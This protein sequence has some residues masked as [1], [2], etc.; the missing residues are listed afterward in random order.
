MI[1]G[2]YDTCPCYP[3]NLCVVH[4]LSQVGEQV[5]GLPGNVGLCLFWKLL[6]PDEGR[7]VK[8]FREAV[9][10]GD[11]A[12][13]VSAGER[14]G[15]GVHRGKLGAA[16]RLE[17]RRGQGPGA[18][19]GLVADPAGVLEGARRVGKGARPRR[20]VAVGPRRRR[21]VVRVPRPVVAPPRRRA[22]PRAARAV[23]PRVA[24]RPA[25]A[26]RPVLAGARHEPLPPL[27]APRYV[28][29]GQAAPRRRHL[30]R[31]RLGRR[32]RRGA[33]LRGRQVVE[34]VVKVG[35]VLLYGLLGRGGV[36]LVLVLLLLPGG[37]AGG[38]G[39]VLSLLV[40]LGAVPA[41]ADRLDL[42]DAGQVRDKAVRPASDVVVELLFCNLDNA[43]Q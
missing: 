4:R 38:G 5:L 22:A 26:G 24:R 7:V 40:P 1:L 42:G 37:A 41:P 27:L 29:A 31:R 15:P 25:E 19:L 32:P 39:G 6:P 30:P 11:S 9:V 28:G 18:P 21:D 3:L 34:K 14:V 17:G 36:V 43:A 33:R 10:G 35:D 16:R 8:V 13:G 2:T 20:R 23:R 12:V